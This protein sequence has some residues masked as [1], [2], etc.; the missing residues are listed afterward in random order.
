MERVGEKRI[1]DNGNN[2][3][4]LECKGI[5][6]KGETTQ[7]QEIIETYWNVKY[8]RHLRQSKEYSEIIETYWNVKW[9]GMGDKNER[10]QK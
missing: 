4:I 10:R 3:N 1:T 5:A 9:N 7:K 8:E 2:R 6:G